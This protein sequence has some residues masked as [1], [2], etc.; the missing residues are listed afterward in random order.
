MYNLNQTAT[1][2]NSTLKSTFRPLSKDVSP[3]FILRSY[4][5]LFNLLL[6][7]RDP[8]IIEVTSSHLD[9]LHQ[10][11]YCLRNLTETPVLHSYTFCMF[12]LAEEATITNI[13]TL[14]SHEIN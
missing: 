13:S 9:I 2:S 12:Y 6:D 4:F 8:F 7:N 11:P 3:H 14:L 10:L 1:I 5:P